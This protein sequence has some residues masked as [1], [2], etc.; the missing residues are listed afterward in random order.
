MAQALKQNLF[1]LIIAVCVLLW[2]LPILAYAEGL[3]LVADPWEPIY[4]PELK[5][6]GFVTEVIQATEPGTTV[7]YFPFKRAMYYAKKGKRGK[8]VVDGIM[9]IYLKESRRAFYEFSVP[10]MEIPLVVVSK[11][12]SQVGYVDINS[13]K[14]YKIGLIAGYSVS[15]SFDAR[16]DILDIEEVGS[17]DLN[18]KKLM[19]GRIDCF[20][21]AKQVV[22]AKAKA[23]GLPALYY[24]SPLATNPIYVGFSKAVP[25][26][27]KRTEQFNKRFL[28]IK[29]DGTYDRIYNSW[30]KH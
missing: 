13:L 16:R 30:F 10:I 8:N 7:Q 3:A 25:G 2:F 9:G 5:Q 26:Y 12:D 21:D 14:Q 1:Q 24:S 15:P 11:T 28:N 18:I 22:Q 4:G 19:R 6:G 29:K 17:L 27:K 20:I 23:M